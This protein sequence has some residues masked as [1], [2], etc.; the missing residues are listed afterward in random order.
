M[1]TKAQAATQARIR[2]AALDFS[3]GDA[4]R[5]LYKFCGAKNRRFNEM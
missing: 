1:A 4:C 3:P 5:R 2:L